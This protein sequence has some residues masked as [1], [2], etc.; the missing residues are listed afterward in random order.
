[1]PSAVFT[2]TP[3]ALNEIAS[4]ESFV[5]SLNGKE[6]AGEME[7]PPVIRTNQTNTT[8]NLQIMGSG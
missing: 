7:I 8:A 2:T 3:W 6:A 5:P 1:L 4:P